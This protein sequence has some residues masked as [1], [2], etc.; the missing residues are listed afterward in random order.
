MVEVIGMFVVHFV[1][2]LV[3]PA[4]LTFLFVGIALVKKRRVLSVVC[5]SIATIIGVSASIVTY[6][7][8]KKRGA[9]RARNS[10]VMEGQEVSRVLGLH[11]IQLLKTHGDS[12]TMSETGSN[13]DEIVEMRQFAAYCLTISSC[14]SLEL[15]LQDNV[16]RAK[17]GLSFW[18]AF[19]FNGDRR[20]GR[21]IDSIHSNEVYVFFDHSDF[22]L[23]P[24]R[25]HVREE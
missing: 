14:N 22:V 12:I 21:S 2:Y 3:V 7:G 1:Y 25:W 17:N 4:F 15:D 16:L 20:I 11:F 13:E 18:L 23:R 8:E 10:L 24:R 19:D 9:I 6:T 5:L